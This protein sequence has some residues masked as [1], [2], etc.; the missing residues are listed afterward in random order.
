[1]ENVMV[2]PI[3]VWRA[4][5][6]RFSRLLDFLE[7]EMARFHAG[8]EPDY[9][10]MC[11]VVYYLRRYGDLFHHQREDVAFS[12]LVER[13]PSL[14][15]TVEG[16]LQ[17]HRTI[18]AAGETLRNCLDDALNDVVVERHAVETAARTYLVGYRQHLETEETVILPRAAQA[19]TD[20]DWSMV[21]CAVAATPDPLF[22]DAVAVRYKSL[23][24]HMA[25]AT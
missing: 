23:R 15:D 19:L 22:G 20:A 5:H 6:K 13:D 14:A 1:M 8:E 16:L 3:A 24:E 2:D 12:R 17:Q 18:A 7:R 21:R 4:E 11:D 25:H 10:L 9:D